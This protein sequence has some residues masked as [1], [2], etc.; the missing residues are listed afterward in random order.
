M[1]ISDNLENWKTGKLVAVLS[2]GFYAFYVFSVGVIEFVYELEDWLVYFINVG[3]AISLIVFCKPASEILNDYEVFR[4]VNIHEDLAFIIGWLT[5][6]YTYWL[7]FI[8]A[9]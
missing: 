7:V 5:L 2:V 3:V 4:H 9:L 8:Y 1:S 6:L